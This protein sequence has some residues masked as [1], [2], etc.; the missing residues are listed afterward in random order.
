MQHEYLIDNNFTKLCYY[1]KAISVDYSGIYCITDNDIIKLDTAN[2]NFEWLCSD[3]DMFNS[4]VKQGI[5]VLSNTLKDINELYTQFC[6]I[7][8][9]YIIA[10]K[11]GGDNNN[12]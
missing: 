5:N 3:A 4:I 11:L 12:E 7:A 6:K 1:A 9:P 8:M 10:Y 2:Y